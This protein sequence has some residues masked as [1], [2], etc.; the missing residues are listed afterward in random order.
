M[1]DVRIYLKDKG[2]L[3]LSKD[4]P[5]ALN[6]AVADIADISKKNGS[7]S[8]TIVLPGTKYNNELL[9]QLYNINVTNST[10]DIN[11]KVNCLIIAGD[12]V[13]MDG[14]FRLLG[15]TKSSPTSNDGDEM[16]EYQCVVFDET[17][18]FFDRLGDSLLEDLDFSQYNHIYSG[19][20][21][22][23]SGSH[24]V[25]DV[26]TY[27]MNYNSNQTNYL[28]TD[29]YPAIYIKAY[30]DKIFDSLQYSYD[31]DF[32]NGVSEDGLFTKLV[33]PFNQERPLNS[34]SVIDSRKFKVGLT[35]ATSSEVFSAQPQTG[36]TNVSQS[37]LIDYNDDTNGTFFDSG[38]T[39]NVG[40][41]TYVS[42]N[43]QVSDFRAR[44]P[45]SFGYSASTDATL[46]N[47]FAGASGAIYENQGYAYNKAA[48][49]L[50]VNGTL[51][52][53]INIAQSPLFFGYEISAGT[54]TIASYNVDIT[55]PNVNLTFGDEVQVKV[56]PNAK[57]IN[58]NFQY[59]NGSTLVIPHY[60]MDLIR[61]V[62]ADTLSF[63]NVPHQSDIQDGDTIFMNDYIPKN[64]K[65]K[66]FIKWIVQMFNLYIEPDK[67]FSNKLK[68]KTRD[69]FYDTNEAIDWTDKFAIDRDS[70]IKF[71][72]ELQNRD[73]ILTY[74]NA[75]DN[76]SKSYSDNWK[77][78]YGRKKFIFDN[79]Y[80]KGEK[81]IEVGF[82]DTML[83][84]N[85]F[86]LIVPYILSDKPKTGIKVLYKPDAWLDGDWTFKYRNDSGTFVNNSLTTYP[87]YGHFD[88]PE[89]PTVDIN[90]GEPREMGY[91]SYGSI[92]DNNLGNRFYKNFVEQMID[93]KMLVGYFDLDEVD[94][95]NLSFSTKIFIKDS[96]YFINKVTDFNPIDNGLTKVE[97]IKVDTGIR[98]NNTNTNTGGIVRPDVDIAFGNIIRDVINRPYVT[99]NQVNS[100]NA[101][102]KGENNTVN[103][104]SNSVV[105]GDG[106]EVIG[107]SSTS[108]YGN[109]N[110]IDGTASNKSLVVGNN[111][112]VSADNA[113]VFGDGITADTRNT[114]YISNV[115]VTESITITSGAT[116]IG[117]GD[118]LPLSGGAMD[119]S[120]VISTDN[121]N[122]QIELDAGGTAN[123]YR[124]STDSGALAQSYHTMTTST[125]KLWA[126]SSGGVAEIFA[127]A[128]TSVGR[129]NTT[130]SQYAQ[131][132]Y[133]DSTG[134]G[135][136]ADTGTQVAKFT[137]GGTY[138]GMAA[139]II[140]DAGEIQVRENT[141]AFATTSASYNNEAVFLGA[142]GARMNAGITNSV[143]LG[144]TSLTGSS[145]NTVYVPDL[146]V[147]GTS[148][149]IPYDMS[150]AV[151]DETTAITSGAG[152]LTFYVARNFSLSKV[153][154]SLTTTGSTT[155]TVDVNVNGSTILTSPVSL[156]SGVYVNS[157]TSISTPNLSEDG[158]ITIDVDAAG[159]GAAG[160]KVYLIGKTR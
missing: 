74:K 52:S 16:I 60:Y 158:R 70:E 43:N 62:T 34:Q 61:N 95:A 127:G 141:S 4:L 48:L 13:L 115:N 58:P 92:T 151:S 20:A 45:M 83:V 9:G 66:D 104:A 65:Q 46:I 77:E 26:Y 36:L 37:H 72:P 112:L 100:V 153:K 121:G 5:V 11:R 64:V 135:I 106:N 3:E 137:T 51:S 123:S 14:Y 147:S 38:N 19:S 79:D 33:V 114:T 128:S 107:E 149:G 31:S 142:K 69:E 39:F 63:L 140:A 131:Y 124:L 103:Y 134:V 113:S 44:F 57:S 75:S 132:V 54:H 42:A 125:N 99:N 85:G 23:N 101:D 88:R 143:I 97:L 102:V 6:Y 87:Y 15:I 152:K 89:L 120:A 139:V 1:K 8:K 10:F 145:S 90:F 157:T 81:K 160:L 27:G 129:W 50:Y 47:Q 82:E 55:F 32:F 108:V 159:T 146:V 21:V 76:L 150:V 7:F 119:S 148:Y 17:T 126:K 56:I 71:L 78:T 59:Y 111:N 105:R 12:N 24:T 41:S 93:G 30:V 84:E 138:I 154:I 116:I 40:T 118:Y 109:D 22:I 29:F 68:I 80:L 53:S 91:W 25:D 98:F 28:L 35:G 94:V 133:C 49:G 117:L 110:K 73:L 96:Y 2:E 136:F 155:T 86:G 156:T 18:N 144:G 130:T 67:D 122:V